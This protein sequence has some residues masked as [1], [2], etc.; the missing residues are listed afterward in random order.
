MDLDENVTEIEKDDDH[1]WTLCVHA[2]SDLTRVSP[3]VFVYLLKEAYFCGM[4]SPP[5]SPNIFSANTK[6]FP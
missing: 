4:I 1:A 6:Y 2:F 5:C 3:V